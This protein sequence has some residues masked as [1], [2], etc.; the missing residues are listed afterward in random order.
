M[1]AVTFVH[2]AVEHAA[3][4]AIL[5]VAFERG[6]ATATGLVVALQLVPAALLAPVV[7]AAGDRFPRHLVL[8]VGFAGLALLA[9]SIAVVLATE[10]S[11]VVVYAGAAVFTVMLGSFPGAIASLLV[12]HADSPTRLTQWNVWQSLMRSAG[13]LVGPLITAVLLAVTEP[14]IVFAT[15]AAACVTTTVAIRVRLPDDDR[16]AT[17]VRLRSILSDSTE[18]VRYVVANRDTR[19]IIGFISATGVLV[20]GL[21]VV[22]VAIAFDRLGGGGS[23]SATLTVAFA[24]G[25]LI[26]AAVI[27]RRLRWPLTTLTTA[28][29]LLV[30]LPLV[31][32]AGREQIGPVLALIALLGAGNALIEIGGFTLLQRACAETTTSRAFGVLDAALLIAMSAGAAAAGALISRT[33][34]TTMLVWLGLIAALTL[35]ALSWSLRQLERRT[36]APA[37]HALVDSLRTVSFLRPLP[38]PTLERLVRNIELREVVADCELITEGDPGDEFFVLLDGAADVT[39]GGQL[40]RRVTAPCS[41]GEIALLHDRPRTAT[42]TTTAPSRL[43]VILRADFLDAIQRSAASHSNALAVARSRWFPSD[44]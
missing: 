14:S 13:V 20:G 40:A 24:T 23:V 38:L 29:V 30:S 31:G 15:I 3:W 35:G 39:I 17:T 32:L 44:E 1:Y 33:D 25:A 16:I 41:F 18:G 12:H 21:D 8:S 22:F 37:D 11:I 4:I 28:G 19:R 10:T 42:I 27:S 6:G 34:L 7:A 26:A 5:V 36:I 2:S 9:G 43:A